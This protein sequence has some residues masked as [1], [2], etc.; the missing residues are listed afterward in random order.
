MVYYTK[1]VIGTGGGKEPIPE[2]FQ[3]GSE[4]YFSQ[5]QG[6]DHLNDGLH[7]LSQLQSPS[8]KL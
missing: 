5:R 4:V 6:A 7:H 3:G 2:L 1:N 8:L